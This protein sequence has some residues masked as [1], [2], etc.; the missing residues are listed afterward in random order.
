M[1][2]NVPNINKFG[3]FAYDTGSHGHLVNQPDK[4]FF[5]SKSSW[6]GDD[7]RAPITNMEEQSEDLILN[8]DFNQTITDDLIDSIG[9]FDVQYNNDH[10]VEFSE[11][12]RIKKLSES[13]PDPIEK[14]R[15]RQAY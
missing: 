12:L 10:E 4:K 2:I 6:D 3:V 7:N 5:G 1:Y 13:L 11:N 15:V 8:I 9:I 14:S